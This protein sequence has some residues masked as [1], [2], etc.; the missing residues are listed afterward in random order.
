M[1]IFLKNCDLIKV[2]ITMFSS[3]MLIVF[4]DRV[5]SHDVIGLF[6]PV[7]K[8]GMCKLNRSSPFAS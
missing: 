6:R 3:K 5:P 4:F 8:K 2:H 1:V 7:F